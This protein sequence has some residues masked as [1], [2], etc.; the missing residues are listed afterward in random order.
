MRICHVASAIVVALS[1]Y[2]EGAASSSSQPAVTSQPTTQTTRPGGTIVPPVRRDV[3]GKRTVLKTGSLFVPDY[4]NPATGTATDVVVWFLGASWCTEQTFY[5]ARKNAILITVNAK[6]YTATF[7]RS[8]AL[9]AIL[10]E[11]MAWL[12]REGVTDK[13]LGR[14][15]LTSFS[16]GYPA[17]REILK[18][19]PLREQ[20]TD[21]VL[22]DSL[23]APRVNGKPNELQP[24]AMAPFLD[25]ALRAARGECSFWFSHL[26]PPEEKYRG[27]TTTLA[28]NYLI[29]HLKA[30]RKPS[31]SLNCRGAELLYRA[32]I[33]NFHVL[34]YAGMTNQD[35]FDHFYAASDLLRNISFSDVPPILKYEDIIEGNTVSG[36]R[37]RKAPKESWVVQDG[38]LHC[39]SAAGK[40]GAWIGS[41]KEYTDLVVELEYKLTPG[42]N[43]GVYIRTPEVGHSSEVAMEIQLLD[44]DAEQYRKL[45]PAQYNG[46]IYKIAAPVRRTA[47]PPGQWNKMRITAIGDHITVE[48]NGDVV[49][50]ADTTSYPELKTRSPRGF[51]GLQDHHS[52]VWFRNIRLAD[53]SQFTTESRPVAP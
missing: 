39:V 38:V 40:W 26:Y 21:V 49:V 2:A 47:K 16:G 48:L 15:C 3:P 35:H 33:G 53:L 37:V 32:D 50:D 8:D 51:I 24:E 43:S 6:D 27:N 34:G 10:D 41:E 9:T 5:D 52:A 13:P 42:A 11:A 17:V 20:I 25:Y 4:Y 23:Y 36:W 14:V 28:A 31:P 45:V 30:E 12:H 29:D 7:A 22:A 19:K 18:Q 46:S 44:D 1:L